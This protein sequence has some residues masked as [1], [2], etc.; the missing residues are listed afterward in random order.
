MK[1]Q[2]V[3]TFDL[4]PHALSLEITQLEEGREHTDILRHVKLPG[5]GCLFS[6]AIPVGSRLSSGHL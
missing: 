3:L 1:L 6:K 4:L 2:F 5:Q